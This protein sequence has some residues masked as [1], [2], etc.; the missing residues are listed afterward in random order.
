MKHL[1]AVPEPPSKLAARGAARPRR[2]RDAR[3]REGPGRAL[4]T[5]PRRWTPTSRASA[6]GA[7]GL[8]ADGGGDDAGAR[9]PSD[10]DRR[11]TM[12]A[13]R[14]GTTAAGAARLPAARRVLRGAAARRSPWPWILGL[15]ALAIAGGDRLPALRQGPGPARR[16]P[17]GRRSSTSASCSSAL[18]KQQLEARGLPRARRSGSRTA[19]VA[20]GSVISAGP[21]RRRAAAEGLD[22]H[23][24]RLDREARSRPCPTSRGL[25][26]TDA[27]TALVHAGLNGEPGL[28]LL[29]PSRAAP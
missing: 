6:R 21:G 5:R 22:R 10:A 3:A 17:A 4:S 25:A 26:Q 24:L 20:S 14:R 1:S 27:I 16:E 18:A 13:A 15:L 11:P 19:T 7:R 2:G 8:A 28:R 9:A 12:V 23:A 29:G